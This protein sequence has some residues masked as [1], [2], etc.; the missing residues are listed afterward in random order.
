MEGWRGGG[1]E[2]WRGG[3]GVEGW[4]GGGVERGWG[5]EGWRGGGV[6]GGVRVKGWS[7]GGVEV[8]GAW[9]EEHLYQL[10]II[11]P[12]VPLDGGSVGSSRSRSAPISPVDF[13]TT[14]LALESCC[15]V[16]VAIALDIA[17]LR[18]IA[19]LGLNFDAGHRRHAHHTVQ[20]ETGELV[21]SLCA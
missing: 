6:G 9:C 20:Y 7:G 1:V 16:V 8:R 2:G 12:H 18:T 4:R 13:A 14:A 11:V 3:V 17:N 21:A 10:G 19:P 15:V 5:G